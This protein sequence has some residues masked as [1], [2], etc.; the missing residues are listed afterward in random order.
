M[1]YIARYLTRIERVTNL[2]KFEVS[3]MTKLLW[4]TFINMT[5][6]VLLVNADFSKYG[7]D[8]IFGDY[9]LNG[10]YDDFNRD[11]YITVGSVVT[12]TLLLAIFA[13]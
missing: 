10:K 9:F 3:A 6:V 4:V 11:W 1:K 7:S 2:T 13:P 12:A 8:E 5:I